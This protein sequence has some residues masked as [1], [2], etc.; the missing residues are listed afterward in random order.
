MKLDKYT[1]DGSEKIRLADVKCGAPKEMKEKRD[2]ITAKTAENVKEL[3]AY[4][5]KLYADGREGLIIVFQARDAAGKD[6]AVKHIMSGINPAGV[7]VYSFKTPSKEELAHDF[8]WRFNKALPERGKI[9]IFNRSY[10]EDVLVVKVRD[11]QKTYRVPAR[12]I[13][14][15]YFDKRY[16]HITNYEDELYEN[17]YEIVKIFLNVSKEK[18]KERFLERI[19]TPEK[20]WKF[21][22][23]DIAERALW[24][25]YTDAYEKMINH[26]STEKCPWYVVPADQK[27]FTHYVI[28]EILLARMKKIDPQFPELPDDEKAKLQEYKELLLNEK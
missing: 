23:G 21:S 5:E 6:S 9:A 10:Y 26:T 25:D 28:S 4:Q 11:L 16:V 13:G 27:W 18:E 17:G 12:T 1:Y 14:K 24:D 19:E 3:S 22:S 20:N 2:E 8:L 15:D 7:D